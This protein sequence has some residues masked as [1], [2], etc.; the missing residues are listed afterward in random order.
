MYNTRS[1]DQGKRKESIPNV[2]NADGEK[3]VR[4]NQHSKVQDDED[5]GEDI[6][7]DD[8]DDYNNDELAEPASKGTRAEQFKTNI[9]LEEVIIKVEAQDHASAQPAYA[10]KVKSDVVDLTQNTDDD[11]APGAF[12]KVTVAS[13]LVCCERHIDLLVLQ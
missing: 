13:L 5:D 1:T 10:A 4:V 9:K 8:D 2:G 12:K 6:D 7:Y 11:D 3:I